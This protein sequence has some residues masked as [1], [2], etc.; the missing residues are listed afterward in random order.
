MCSEDNCLKVRESCKIVSRQI[1]K[2]CSFLGG[3]T[4]QCMVFTWKEALTILISPSSKM[5]LSRSYKVTGVDDHSLHQFTTMHFR[6]LIKP[7]YMSQG[8]L[9]EI[10]IV[11]MRETNATAQFQVYLEEDEMRAST[12]FRRPSLL[13]IH[14]RQCSL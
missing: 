8:G 6:D 13:T 11:T 1:K 9:Q 7:Y 14:E 2:T 12:T 5:A 3:K 10:E 4:L